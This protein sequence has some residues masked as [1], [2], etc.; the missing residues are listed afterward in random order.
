MTLRIKSSEVDTLAGINQALFSACVRNAAGLRQAGRLEEAAQ[1]CAVGAWSASNE[2]W[3]GALSSQ[4]LETELLQTAA[5]LPL[6]KRRSD[7]RS[8]PHWL[9]V[10]SEA[11]ATL[12]HTNLCRRWIQYDPGVIHDVMLV[13]QRS[14]IPA[15]LVATVKN[16]GGECRSLDFAAPLLQRAADLRQYAWEN[17]DVVVLHTH[18]DEVLAN[19]AF[20]VNGGPPVLLLNH[21]DHAFWVG[22]A[23]ADLVL[24]IR[25]SGQQWTKRV[26]G[27][28]R[29]VLLPIPLVDSGDPETKNSS[30]SRDGRALRKAL[31]IPDDATIVL[32]VGS[33][34]KYKSVP[35]LDF[36]ATAL[37]I[38]RRC[39]NT[40]L[41]AVGP[42]DEGPWRS[43]RQATHGRVRAVGYQPDSA[44]FCRGSDLYLEGFPA[45]SLTALLEAGLSGLAC[46]RAPRD[47][48]PPF[49]SDGMALEHLPQ[50]LDLDEYVNTVVALAKD[51]KARA[52]IGLRLQ[53]VIRAHH[54]GAGWL[55]HLQSVK[56]QI[57]KEHQ[58][59]PDFS[60]SCVNQAARDWYFNY[61]D[62]EAHRDSLSALAAPVFVEAW[63]RTNR[64]P[65][66]GVDLWKELKQCASSANPELATGLNSGQ[67]LD[68]LKLWWLNQRIKARGSSAKCMAEAD[69][70]YRTG[71]ARAGRRAVYR[72]LST[73]PGM[74]A[75]KHWLKLFVKLH[76]SRSL[77]SKWQKSALSRPRPVTLARP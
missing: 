73:R 42:R 18:P 8:R 33:A 70:A 69:Q 50:P 60:P 20:G 39:D 17:A 40:Y 21:A 15:N 72:C 25:M 59:H 67:Y 76:V 58:V 34:S 32:T 9:H 16:A 56:H 2:G 13:S 27:V 11:Y 43:A 53:E 1:W 57:P 37:E 63:K 23:V 3:F 12:G 24:D 35:G 48:V 4:S 28:D 38:V 5:H 29:S 26:R 55:G 74:L 75:D 14:E 77:L 64:R 49:S 22:C 31:G 54:C 7:A 41:V 6:P 44:L 51:P 66:I 68:R 19:V 62:A 30:L 36:V 65:Q 46:V 47:C 45:G 10:L 52:G 71:K 61:L